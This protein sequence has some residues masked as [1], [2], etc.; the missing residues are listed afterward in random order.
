MWIINKPHYCFFAILRFFK[1][2]YKDRCACA[3]ALNTTSRCETSVVLTLCPKEQKPQR[4][5]LI[6]QSDGK[7]IENKTKI[8]NNGTTKKP[9]W[10][11]ST[12]D[13]KFSQYV[14]CIPVYLLKWKESYC[15]ITSAKIISRSNIWFLLSYISILMLYDNNYFSM[16]DKRISLL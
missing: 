11:I 8:G 12:C 2:D 14:R 9:C 6:I 16:C 4:R 13:S 3:E 1:S 7:P 5:D 15:L 10:Q